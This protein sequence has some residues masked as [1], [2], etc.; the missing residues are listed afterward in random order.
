M[1]SARYSDSDMGAGSVA[2][3]VVV[4]LILLIYLTVKAINLIVRAFCKRP[5]HKALWTALISVAVSMLLTLL[6]HGNAITVMLTCISVLVLLLTTY[7]IDV[8][9]D[10]LFQKPPETLVN[11]VLHNSWWDMGDSVAA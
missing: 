9:Y 2:F 8:Y 10:N 11:T 6:T 1:R 3:L 7:I 5:K 4:L